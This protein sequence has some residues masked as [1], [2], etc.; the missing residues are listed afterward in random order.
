MDAKI[1]TWQYLHGLKVSSHKII[2]SY[3]EKNS[4]ITVQKFGRNHF[5]QG[6]KVS[7]NIKGTNWYHMPS[8]SPHQKNA[9]SE[10]NHE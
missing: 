6:T 8:D 5:N 10:F 7:L 9:Q 1:N 2:I 3:K 4:N